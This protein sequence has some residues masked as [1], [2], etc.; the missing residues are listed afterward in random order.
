[1][2]LSGQSRRSQRIRRS[3]QGPPIAAG[4]AVLLEE[5]Y[6]SGSRSPPHAGPTPRRQVIRCPPPPKTPPSGEGVD[7]RRAALR[8]TERRRDVL[9]GG[10]A[11]LLAAQPAGSPRQGEGP[12]AR[13]FECIDHDC[14][15]AVELQLAADEVSRV[16]EQNPPVAIQALAEGT[17]RPAGPHRGTQ[18]F[19]VSPCRSSPCRSLECRSGSRGGSWS[20]RGR[21]TPPGSSVPAAGCQSDAQTCARISLRAARGAPSARRA[22]AAPERQ[23]SP[24]SPPAASARDNCRRGAS[25][26]ADERSV[27]TR[28]QAEIERVRSPR[29]RRRAAS[30]SRERR[31]S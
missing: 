19:S 22:R 31:A 15:P 25:I 23:S 7:P 3:W 11:R 10:L 6:H 28:S 13:A 8:P 21:R 18:R 16:G 1:M 12:D 4:P 14:E 9:R 30:G 5:A 24:T 26:A 17:F 2:L 27:T 20:G 29:T